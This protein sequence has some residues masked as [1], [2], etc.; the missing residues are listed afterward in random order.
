MHDA[1]FLTDAEK[2]DLARSIDSVEKKKHCFGDVLKAIGDPKVLAHGF[3]Y[4]TLLTALYGVIYW[5]P[6]VVKTFGVTGTQN[7]LLVAFPWA[8]DAVLLWL[9]PS[10]V[11][12]QDNLKAL[13][14]VLLL[15]SAAFAASALRSEEH[16]SELQSLMS[17]SYA[18]F[19]LTKKKQHPNITVQD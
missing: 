5:A 17:S 13:I 7:G 11:R 2:A 8:V 1:T 18:V 19:C 6:T 14:I 3:G 9:I 10:R 4:I 16:T 12:S 15:G